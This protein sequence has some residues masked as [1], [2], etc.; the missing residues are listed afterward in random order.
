MSNEVM[1]E[2]LAKCV[3]LVEW[4]EHELTLANNIIQNLQQGSIKK[5]KPQPSMAVEEPVDE[6]ACDF[7]VSDNEGSTS[8]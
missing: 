4:E 1:N 5:P 3:N 7:E 2:E 8:I 6:H